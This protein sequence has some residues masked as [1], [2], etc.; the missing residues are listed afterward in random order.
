MDNPS[1]DKDATSQEAKDNDG[2][3]DASE[4]EVIDG[5]I[6]NNGSDKTR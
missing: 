5:D 3:K 6:G 2:N 4:I 1:S